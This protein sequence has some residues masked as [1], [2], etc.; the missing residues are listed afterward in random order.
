MEMIDFALIQ[1]NPTVWSSSDHQNP[2]LFV[3]TVVNHRPDCGSYC[4]FIKQKADFISDNPGIH[5][6][7]IE[8]DE[9]QVLTRVGVNE[10]INC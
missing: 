10:I 7:A 6:N 8:I 9:N 2:S 4:A 5:L 3:G 1:L